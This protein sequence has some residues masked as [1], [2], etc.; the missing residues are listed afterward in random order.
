MHMCGHLHAP[1]VLPTG[2]TTRTHYKRGCVGS[3]PCWDW[4][5]GPSSQYPSHYTDW[6]IRLK[7]K[8]DRKDEDV[9]VIIKEQWRKKKKNEE[10][11]E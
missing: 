3:R 1:A 4:N 2:M 9:K 7:E 10:R 6:A 8:E 11:K 5:P